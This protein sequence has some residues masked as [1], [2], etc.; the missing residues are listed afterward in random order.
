MIELGMNIK[1]DLT[2]F[3]IHSYIQDA[4]WSKDR[5]VRELSTEGYF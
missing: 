2:Y 5:I 4:S 1:L 3:H